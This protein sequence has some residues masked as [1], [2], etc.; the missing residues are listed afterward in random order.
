MSAKATAWACEQKLIGRKKQLL[1]AI[2]RAVDETSA[3]I[4]PKDTVE[5][6]LATQMAAVHIETMKAT[7]RLANAEFVP[8]HDSA[9]MAVNKFARTFAAQVEALKKHRSV[10]EQSIRVEHV[11]VNAGGQAIVGVVHPQK[12]RGDAK[13]KSQSHEPL[14]CDAA[15]AALPCDLK[16]IGQTL[17]SAGRARMEGLPL[18]RSKG[19]RANGAG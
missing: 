11:T 7:Y 1:L 4:E 14:G 16:A 15:G 6:L 13:I 5:A 10:G 3:C 18:S 17:P 19:R 2:A 8:Q 12:G 9:L